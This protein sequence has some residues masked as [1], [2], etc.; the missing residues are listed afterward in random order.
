[1]LTILG[2]VTYGLSIV[3]SL[4][5]IDDRFFKDILPFLVGSLFTLVF[6]IIII[7]QTIKYKKQGG[8][9]DDSQ[10]DESRIFLTADQS[11]DKRV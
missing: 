9:E 6:D 2:N 7:Y 1:M 8:D 3:F 4:P 5:P 11:D 10:V